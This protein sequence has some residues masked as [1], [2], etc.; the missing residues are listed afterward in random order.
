MKHKAKKKILI[1]QASFKQKNLVKASFN[2]KKF[3]FKQH[4]IPK[5]CVLVSFTTEKYMKS[6][7]FLQ[8]II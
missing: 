5:I 6:C 7:E 1:W 4:L 3:S 2:T 8:V